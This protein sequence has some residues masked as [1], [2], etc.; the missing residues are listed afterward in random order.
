MKTTLAAITARQYA[1]LQLN[2]GRIQGGSKI[3][4]LS[5]YVG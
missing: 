3:T 2:T 1:V 5:E 4:L